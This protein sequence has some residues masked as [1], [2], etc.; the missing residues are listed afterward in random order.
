MN[1]R[2]EILNQ[3]KLFN[4]TLF[5]NLFQNDSA[6]DINHFLKS[7]DTPKLPTDQII[8][9]VL[10]LIRKDMTPWKAWKMKNLRKTMV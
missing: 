2:A 3:V 9:C 8:L 5:Q 10:E 6:D 4:E 1:K 7:L